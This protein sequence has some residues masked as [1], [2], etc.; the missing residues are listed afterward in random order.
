MSGKQVRIYNLA[1]DIPDQRDYIT[2]FKLSPHVK[3]CTFAQTC[4]NRQKIK[5]TKKVDNICDENK[6]NPQQVAVK[7]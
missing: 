2:Y 5:R 3:E 1:R 6:R 7:V 4:S